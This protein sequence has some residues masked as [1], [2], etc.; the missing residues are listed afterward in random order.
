[1]ETALQDPDF[2]PLAMT[3][4]MFRGKFRLGLNT[5]IAIVQPYNPKVTGKNVSCG[6]HS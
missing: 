2:S 1:V 5:Y 4:V 3:L 6:R